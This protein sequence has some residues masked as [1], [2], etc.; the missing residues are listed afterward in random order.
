MTLSTLY[1][2]LAEDGT[3]QTEKRFAKQLVYF[4]SVFWHLNILTHLIKKMRK[5]QGAGTSQPPF[6]RSRTPNQ[7]LFALL[8]E[9]FS[10]INNIFT[11]LTRPLSGT[12]V[13]LM[14][15]VEKYL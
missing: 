1:S 6:L 3:V 5:I 7:N 8:C 15:T 14:K 2:T 10:K 11:K 9:I 13:K 12:I 4:P